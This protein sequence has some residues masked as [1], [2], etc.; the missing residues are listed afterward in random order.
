MNSLILII[1]ANIAL[2]VANF[3]IGMNLTSEFNL[4]VSGFCACYAWHIFIQYLD[5]KHQ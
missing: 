1:L 4:F 3:Y 2:S 5:E